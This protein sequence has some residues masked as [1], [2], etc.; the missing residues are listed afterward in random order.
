[1]FE[2]LVAAWWI[3]INLRIQLD[4][5]FE[6]KL[7]QAMTRSKFPLVSDITG[8]IKSISLKIVLLGEERSR[9]RKFRHLHQ[10]SSMMALV[11]KIGD[12]RIWPS[13]FKIKVPL[14]SD[15]AGSIK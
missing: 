3:M 13:Y 7:C 14:V 9:E 8:Y 4:L 11:P 15:G 2:K 1:M 12:F 5:I 6:S 10:I